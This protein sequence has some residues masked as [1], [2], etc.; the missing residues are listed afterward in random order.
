[1]F[2]L[3]KTAY[4]EFDY[5]FDSVGYKFIMTSQ[6]V[7]KGLP[8]GFPE[9]NYELCKTVS[10]FDELINTQF[11]GDVDNF[12]KYLYELDEKVIV[13]LTK[14]DLFKLQIQY[15]KSVL[16][17]CSIEDVY[18]IHKSFIES[19]RVRSYIS[20]TVID[21]RN[22]YTRKI[23][24]IPSFESF[25]ALADTIPVSQFLKNSVNRE[26]LS[27]EYLL[28]DFLYRGDSSPYK[29]ELLKRVKLITWD[30]WADELEQLRL[31][32]IFGFLDMEILE[33]G[34][35]IDIG[36]I[37]SKIKSTPKLAWIFD[38]NFKAD[39][40]YIREHHDYTYFD[41]IFARVYSVWN[42]QE[43]MAELNEMIMNEQYEEL[44]NRDIDRGFGCLYTFELF[45]EKSNQVL[46]AYLYRKKRAGQT[47][48]LKSF[49]LS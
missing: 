2:H 35:S 14:E 41:D 34:L 19:A 15:L 21:Y 5:K 13:Y 1:M 30:N 6:S 44:L 31:E 43:D 37:E 20:T 11:D 36:E 47:S 12:W 25:Y 16:V 48:D 33:D 10:S 24:E 23:L 40:D 4:L 45:K 32:S 29:E 3:F 17:N 7:T 38:E 28:G 39:P 22:F 42:G 26:T 27:F 9:S 18:L 46:A 8:M 49:K